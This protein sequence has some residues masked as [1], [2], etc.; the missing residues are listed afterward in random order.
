MAD[1][2]RDCQDMRNQVVST[3]QHGK[4]RAKI[5]NMKRFNDKCNYLLRRNIS[6]LSE[7]E[8]HILSLNDQIGCSVFSMNEKKGKIRELQ[9]LIEQAKV[10][11]ELKP[12][13]EELKKVKYRF[14]KAKEKYRAEHDTELSRFYM[15]KRKLKKLD[16][17]KNLF[18]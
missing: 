18:L 4:K 17:K 9:Q 12:I 13:A 14:K 1:L 15:V 2:L 8:N 5:S 16:L 7:L 6:T 11:R 10:Y 3:Y